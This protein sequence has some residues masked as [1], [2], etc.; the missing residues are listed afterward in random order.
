MQLAFASYQAGKL[1]EAQRLCAQALDQ[2]PDHPDA[3]HLLG[4]IAAQTK[5]PD[6]A[7]ELIRRAIAVNPSVADY[8]NNLANVLRGLGRTDESIAAARRAVQLNPDFAA[9]HYTLG[10]CL[11]D[12]GLLEESAGAYREAIRLNPGLVLAHNNLGCVLRELARFDEAIAAFRNA[13]SVKGDFAEGYNNLG[14]ALRERGSPDEAIEAYRQ[15]LKL[16]PNL[17]VAHNNLGIAFYNKCQP[18]EAISA[19]R[20]SLRLMPDYAEAHH[21][22]ATALL[23]KGDFEQGFAEYEWRWCWRGIAPRRAEYVEPRWNGTALGGKKIVLHFEGGFG[24][25]IQFARYAPIVADLGGKVVLECQAELIRLI[26]SLDGVEELVS[27][28]GPLPPFDEHCRLLSLPLAL[29]TRLDT[30]PANVPYLNPEEEL[31]RQWSQRLGETSGLKVGLVWAGNPSHAKDRNRS[32]RAESLAPLARVNG[33]T[34][35]SLQKGES[36]QPSPDF[37]LIDHTSELNDFA[38]TAAFMRNLDLVIAADTAVAHVAGAIGRPVWVL[39]PYAP[40]W[41][42][43]MNRQDSPW[44]PT[45]RLFRQKSPGDW[46]EVIERVASALVSD[47]SI[48]TARD[49]MRIR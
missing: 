40:D 24:D 7:V 44:Y 41:R 16:S 23:L 36:V 26:R 33:V 19:Y 15:A 35:Y 25:T 20:Q 32:L 43:L 47:M 39:I 46:A 1:A 48:L 3:L 42:W 45:M 34:F 27:A 2:S 38:D 10:N 5:H 18:D 21:N 4:G 12:K 13:L 22:L 49:S 29:G 6:R 17:A 31:S 14:N 9:A 30:I 11:H 8:H 37:N 28:G